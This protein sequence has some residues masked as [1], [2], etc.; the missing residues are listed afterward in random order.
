MTVVGFVS[1]YNSTL[2]LTP[3]AVEGKAMERVAAP[4][5]SPEAGAV[6]AGTVVTIT[7]PT[8]GASIYYTLDGT[9]PTK[10]STLYTGGITVS[11]AVTVK[12]VATKEGMLDSEVVTASYTIAV[13]GAMTA[14]FDFSAPQ[15]L[16]PAQT[17]PEAGKETSLD[18]LTLTANAISIAFDKNGASTAP[19]LWN[20]TGA[21][22][23]QIDFRAYSKNT[24]TVTATG[25]TIVSIT[26][27]PRNSSS[28]WKGFT[29]SVAGEWTA[30]NKINVFTPTTA[31]PSVILTASG[32][33]NIGSIEVTYL[34]TTTGITA[35]EAN[36]DAAPVE[37]YNIQGMRV[38]AD[39]LTPG[40]YIRRQGRAAT[41][42]YVK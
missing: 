15:S 16:N 4:A 42:I 5:F 17:A 18:G 26:F 38:N 3:I 12:A 24:L 31:E 21:S 41:K 29:T 11:D 25:A 36:D 37:Y 33:S 8:E 23:G 6:A 14:V 27:N 35:I 1:C 34:P 10:A 30:N 9:E 20:P 2:Q 22:T 32:T 39:N 28:N 13:E 19:R 40:L 7:S